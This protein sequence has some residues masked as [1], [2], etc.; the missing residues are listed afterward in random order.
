MARSCFFSTSSSTPSAMARGRNRS[1]RLRALVRSSSWDMPPSVP[2]PPAAGV[3]VQRARA[4]GGRVED[5]FWRGDDH[6]PLDA[7][8]VGSGGA[9]ET[10]RKRVALGAVDGRWLAHLLDG[11]GGASFAVPADGLLAPGR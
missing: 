4:L 9:P 6:Q 5:L 3:A 2:A 8:L 11:E 1:S 7:A 10:A